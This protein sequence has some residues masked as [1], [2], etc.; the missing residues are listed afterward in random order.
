MS[1]TP[2]ISTSNHLLIRWRKSGTEQIERIRTYLSASCILNWCVYT[3]LFQCHHNLQFLVGQA[4]VNH[5]KDV[6]VVKVGDMRQEC[7]SLCTTRLEES[8]LSLQFKLKGCCGLRRT[9]GPL[10]T[11]LSSKDSYHSHSAT[12]SLGPPENSSWKNRRVM[13][14]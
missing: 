3:N 2:L 13:V 10:V 5:V 14:A 11:L 4:L 7:N 9:M 8:E 6:A 12:N 1:Q